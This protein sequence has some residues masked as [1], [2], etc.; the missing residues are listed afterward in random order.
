MVHVAAVGIG[1]DKKKQQCF[2][3]VQTKDAPI[4]EVWEATLVPDIAARLSGRGIGIAGL[5]VWNRPMPLDPRHNSKIVYK[6]LAVNMAG[7]IDLIRNCDYTG[8]PTGAGLCVKMGEHH[9]LLFDQLSAEDRR[10]DGGNEA[11]ASDV[12]AK[13]DMVPLL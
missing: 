5:V 4:R 10:D 2:V 12:A 7:A 1:E 11:K 3:V 8:M 6:Q 9:A 13:V